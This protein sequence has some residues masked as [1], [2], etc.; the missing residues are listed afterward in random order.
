MPL[1]QFTLSGES[2]GAYLLDSQRPPGASEAVWSREGTMRSCKDMGLGRA[3]AN[4]ASADL[5]ART[6]ARFPPLKVRN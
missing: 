3:G 4:E 1:N 6:A 5:S 2:I